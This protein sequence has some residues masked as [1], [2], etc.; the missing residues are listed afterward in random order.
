MRMSH[1]VSTPHEGRLR[2]KDRVHRD[3]FSDCPENRMASTTDDHSGSSAGKDKG[4][5]RRRAGRE[6]PDERSSPAIKHVLLSSSRPIPPKEDRPAQKSVDTGDT[7]ANFDQFYHLTRHSVGDVVLSRLGKLDQRRLWDWEEEEEAATTTE[8]DG[9][10]NNSG[11]IKLPAD[12]DNE[13]TR[14]ADHG[15]GTAEATNGDDDSEVASA[16]KTKV[17]VR[18]FVE[19]QGQIALGSEVI[20]S[21]GPHKG[22]VGE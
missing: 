9:P 22:F 20:I 15:G 6:S 1:I 10:N 7:R 13:S 3:S 16:P 11:E 5:K 19:P 2:A 18:S 14:S 12:A 8:H 4:R 21:S 17:L